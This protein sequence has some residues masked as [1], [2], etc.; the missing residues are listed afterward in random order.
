VIAFQVL[1][2]FREGGHY[3][4]FLGEQ[5]GEK[6]MALWISVTEL[7]GYCKDAFKVI[8]VFHVT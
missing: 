8:A 2:R 7:S 6:Q 5:L 4:V 3:A 1:F